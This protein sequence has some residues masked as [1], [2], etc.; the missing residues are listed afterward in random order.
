MMGDDYR[1][2]YFCPV[3]NYNNALGGGGAKNNPH[4]MV[5]WMSK[6]MNYFYIGHL[7]TTAKLTRRSDLSDHP[8]NTL[9]T[10]GGVFNAAPMHTPDVFNVLYLGGDVQTRDHEPLIDTPINKGYPVH[11]VKKQG[12]V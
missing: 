8:G 1:N 5:H 2:L 10:D 12:A 6:Q 3:N 7:Y 11:P 9:M 4:L